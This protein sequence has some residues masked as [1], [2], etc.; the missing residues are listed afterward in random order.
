MIDYIRSMSVLVTLATLASSLAGCGPIPVPVPGGHD[1]RHCFDERAPYYCG[2][3][4]GMCCP[5]EFPFQCDGTTKC[6][7]ESDLCKGGSF[8]CHPE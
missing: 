6:A 3:T 1:E 8:R 7:K 5:A 2:F 4:S